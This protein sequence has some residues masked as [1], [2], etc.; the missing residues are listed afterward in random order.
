LGQSAEREGRRRGDVA[1]EAEQFA[2]AALCR[3]PRRSRPDF[4]GAAAR[5]GEFERLAGL[6]GFIFGSARAK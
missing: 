2:H 6:H 1:V 3:S 5:S 4:A